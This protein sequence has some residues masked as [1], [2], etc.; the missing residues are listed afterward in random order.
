M[1]AYLV[2]VSIIFRGFFLQFGQQFD[3]NFMTILAVDTSEVLND[4]TTAH[5]RRKITSLVDKRF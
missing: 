4:H 3:K 2:E 1:T 5:W